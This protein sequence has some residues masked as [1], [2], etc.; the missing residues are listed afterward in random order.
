MLTNGFPIF[1]SVKVREICY[2]YIVS[3]QDPINNLQ[4]SYSVL[5]VINEGNA[6]KIKLFNV[7]FKN[8]EKKEI[9]FKYYEWIRGTFYPPKEDSDPYTILSIFIRYSLLN[10][11][12]LRNILNLRIFYNTVH[13]IFLSFNINQTRQIKRFIYDF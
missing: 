5:S 9:G 2:S 10:L 13:I 11:A 4:Y 8:E 6:S 7:H 3:W 1:F 12:L